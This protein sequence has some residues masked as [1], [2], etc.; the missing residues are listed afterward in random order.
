MVNILL[1]VHDAVAREC[2]AGYLRSRGHDVRCLGSTNDSKQRHKPGPPSVLILDGELPKGETRRFLDSK[3][4]DPLLT[5]VPVVVLANPRDRDDL[6]ALSRRGVRHVVLKASFT[7]EAL[8]ARIAASMNEGEATASAGAAPS[9][10]PDTEAA[11]PIEAKPPGAAARRVIEDVEVTS[12]ATLKG[13]EPLVTPDELRKL[14]EKSGELHA[15]SPAVSRVMQM[16]NRPDVTVDELAKVIKQDP[17]IAMKVLKVANSAVYARGAPV[18]SVLMAVRRIGMEQI[19]Q[20][21]VSIGIVEGFSEPGKSPSLNMHLF[22]EH[23]LAVGLFAAG[24]VNATGGSNSDTDAAFTMG[25]L[26]DVGRVILVE[27]LGERYAQVMETSRQL[28]LPLEIV[29]RKLLGLTHA[30][31]MEKLLTSWRFAASMVKPV[32]LHHAT[33]SAMQQQ[34]PGSLRACLAVALGDRLAHAMMIGGSG[35]ETIAP[36]DEVAKV[37]GLSEAALCGLIKNVPPQV[38]ELKV[39]M[40]ASAPSVGWPSRSRD[41]LKRLPEGFRPTL[42]GSERP[43]DAGAMLVASMRHAGGEGP[44]N[45]AIVNVTTDAEA[46]AAKESLATLDKEAGSSVPALVLGWTGEP[47]HGGRAVV[48]MRGPF[49]FETLCRAAQG[50]LKAA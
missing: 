4:S 39:A 37:M 46:T 24:A 40:L 21:M 31:L 48:E 45:L 3:A 41:V 27:H 19:R 8:E 14:I 38:E 50:L 15:L 6:A 43:T 36:V 9:A 17:A 2:L 10:T 20:T 7:L 16:A 35:G 23:S 32:V 13:M 28:E 26:H 12:R 5:N 42:V 18:D 22:W 33:I 11:R 34:A 44:A 49:Q 47:L 30:D 29:E 1:V 25:L